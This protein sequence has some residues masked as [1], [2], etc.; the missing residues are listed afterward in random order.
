MRATATRAPTNAATGAR[1][2]RRPRPRRRPTMTSGDAEAGARRRAEQVRVGQRVAEHALV[3]GAGRRRAIDADQQAEHDPGQADLPQRPCAAVS[4]RP[5]SNHSSSRTTS[6]SGIDTGPKAT[7]ATTA[8]TT[9]ATPAASHPTRRRGGR[10]H[11]DGDGERRR[12]TAATV[13]H[14]HAAVAS[15]IVR[16][17]STTRGPQRLATSSDELDDVALGGTAV[18]SAKPGR[19]ATVSAVWPQHSVS[20]RKMKS[21]SASTRN[22]GDSCG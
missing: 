19:A 1:D 9:A 15:M 6:P 10:G 12:R 2:R 16:R 18:R 11:G 22:S 21:G 4:V 8:T 13:S 20:A 5:A 3:A 14:R 7:P 17:R